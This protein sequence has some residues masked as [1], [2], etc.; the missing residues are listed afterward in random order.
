MSVAG[1]L[2][3]ENNNISSVVASLRTARL[4][5]MLLSFCPINISINNR[6]VVN[7]FIETML[8]NRCILLEN[9]LIHL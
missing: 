9:T 2:R 6:L 4:I 7:A 5:L 3:A 8:G 1:A